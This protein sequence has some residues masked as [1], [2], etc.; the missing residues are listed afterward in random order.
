ME[1][2]NNFSSIHLG[3]ALL[4][5]LGHQYVLMGSSVPLIFGVD[6]NGI[7][8]RII[9]VMSGYLITESYMRSKSAGQY[10]GKRLMRI[11]PPLAACIFLTVV[12][13][14]PI[15]TRCGLK[16]YFTGSIDYAVRNI[17]MYPVFSLP[18]VFQDNV[19][20]TAVNGSLWT[21]PV[22]MM[23]YILLIGFMKIYDIL[24][25]KSQAAAKIFYASV[26]IVLW[27]IYVLRITGVLQHSLV[28]WGTDWCS[29]IGVAVYFLWG[30]IFSRLGLKN[31]CNL[32]T[33]VFWGMI[34]GCVDGP[35]R[36]VLLL[37]FVTYI[38]IAFAFADK[39]IF[40]KLMKNNYS[41]GIYLWAF[42]IQQ[43]VIQV[44]M[45]RGGQYYSPLV[46]FLISMVFIWMAACLSNVLI[47]KPLLKLSRRGRDSR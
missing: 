39:P 2:E 13:I 24:S 42:P 26:G 33:A 11:Y 6:I 40:S 35:L 16:E 44:I 30:S 15:F 17:A 9:F 37:P 27:I 43:S 29:A 36:A 41:Y 22:E 14:G 21:L 46:M 32:Q 45:I 1:K 7:G 47:E 34:C 12:V 38:T 18:G 23:C 20:Q 28:F 25:K 4:V 8:V 3:A 10:M 19:N 5:V 31:I